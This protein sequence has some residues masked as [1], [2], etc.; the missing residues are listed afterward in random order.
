MLM[1]ILVLLRAF[2]LACCGHRAIVLEN[3]AL[4][5]QLEALKRANPRP[6]LRRRDRLFWIVIGHAADKTASAISRAAD[7]LH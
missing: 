2:T 4:R 3:L 7:A 6:P 1:A 5:Q